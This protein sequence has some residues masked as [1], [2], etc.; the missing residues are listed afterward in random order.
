MYGALQVL[1]TKVGCIHYRHTQGHDEDEYDN[2]NDDDD[3]E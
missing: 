3:D 1:Y 2:D